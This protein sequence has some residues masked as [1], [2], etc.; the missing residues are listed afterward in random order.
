[1]RHPPINAAQPNDAGTRPPSVRR[2]IMGLTPA[3][4]PAARGSALVV[5]NLSFRYPRGSPVLDGA[6]LRIDAG[7]VT[8]LLGANGSGKS[9][10]LGA[11]TNA[12]EGE[13][14]GR[15]AVGADAAGPIGYATQDVALYL[16]L[17]VAENLAHAAPVAARRWMVD[18]LV[19]QALD[20]FGL[21][22]L[23]DR[24][25][26]TLSGGQQ[27]MAHLACS[28]V[29]RPAIRL[30]DEPTTA[31]DFSTR[32]SLIDLVGTWREQGVATL[33]TA[34]YPEDVEELC[35]TITLLVDGRTYDLGSLRDYLDRQH[36]LGYVEQLV[37]G[38][39]VA[40]T[41]FCP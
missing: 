33:V 31:L 21:R 34:H 12:I 28:F 27:R 14:R 23:R 24:L 1:M 26:M 13:R 38:G 11:I 30:L 41:P 4:S 3:G 29:H 16:H 35:S 8:G 18:D 19:E 7:R 32:Q 20:D 6:A 5:E 25:A 10:L 22:A 36:R 2:P 40:S 17:T 37:S 9:T 39:K 15:I